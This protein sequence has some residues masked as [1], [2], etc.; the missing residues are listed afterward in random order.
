MAPIPSGVWLNRVH[1]YEVKGEGAAT[2]I[3][4]FPRSC[5][6]CEDAGLRHRLPDRCLLQARR[7]MASC[8]SIPIPASAASSVPG[9][10]PMARANMTTHDGVMK[11]C[12]LCVDRIYNQHLEA[13]D[14]QPACVRACP[15]GARHFGDLGD[16]DSAVSRLVS[17]RGGYDLLPEL[18]YQPVNKYLPPRQRPGAPPR[19]EPPRRPPAG[20]A[21][22]WFPSRQLLRLGRPGARSLTA[23]HPAYS[24]IVFSTLSGAGYGLLALAALAGASHGPASSFAFGALVMAI[25]LGLVTLGLLASTLHLGHPERAWRAMSQWRSSWLSREGAAAL[26]TYL[27]ALVFGWLWLEPA[28]SPAAIRSAGVVLA[29]MCALTVICT[30]MIYASLATIRQW[31]HPLVLPV[32]LVMALATGA[33]LSACHCGALRSRRPGSR[34]HRHC[35][36]H[37]RHGAQAVVLARHRP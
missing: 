4:H 16:R 17:E 27:P 3:V 7:R 21:G 26:A 33:R 24:V 37:R 10:A 14:R 8:W 13:A 28:S 2:R 9:P 35:R 5:L 18:G 29:L 20:R 11:K 36:S 31:R 34:R 1:G 32:Y 6:H 22:R 12:T 30:A 23:L 25:G 19:T 15:T